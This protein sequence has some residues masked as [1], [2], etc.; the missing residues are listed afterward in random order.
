MT[1]VKTKKEWYKRWWAIALFVIVGLGILSNLFSEET[2]TSTSSS[3]NLP[4]NPQEQT[5][6]KTYSLGD[7]IQ[8][9]NFRWKI[10]K[11]STATEI[12]QYIGDTFLGE[13]AD[14]NFIIVDVEV[15][16]TGTSAKYLMDSYLKLIDE[17][18]REFSPN[19]V[20]AI[21]LKPSGS[22]LMFEQ[23]NPGIIKK[24]KIVFDVPT[25]LKVANIRL[26]SNLVSSSFYNVKLMI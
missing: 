1:E 25:G 17:Q 10:T 6:V 21:Y 8:A 16:N 9:G 7:S 14:G 18:N 22:A 23:I 4:T 24:G 11:Y 26:S 20:A 5:T 13:K 3:S 12:G 15:E 2:S 19:S